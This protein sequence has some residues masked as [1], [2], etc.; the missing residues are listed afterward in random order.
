MT[1]AARS[2]ALLT[3]LLGACASTG[4]APPQLP[5]AQATSEAPAAREPEAQPNREVTA[6]SEAV[7]RQFL[8]D[9]RGGAW[10]A[11]YKWLTVGKVYWVMG[12][13]DPSRLVAVVGDGKPAILLTGDIAALK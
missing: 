5:A 9:H 10:T 4:S 13:L 12:P 1:R 11:G 2:I 6:E 7:A 8:S 3:Q